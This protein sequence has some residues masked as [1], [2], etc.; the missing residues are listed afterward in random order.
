LPPSCWPLPPFQPSLGRASRLPA[1]K[2]VF[3]DLKQKVVAVEAKDGQSL[4]DK[5]ITDE[6]KDAG[7]DVTKLETIDQSVAEIKAAMKA[8]K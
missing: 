2:A 5:T 6:I 8:R 3:V 1:A 4:D 7:Y